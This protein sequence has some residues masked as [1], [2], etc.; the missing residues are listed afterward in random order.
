MKLENQV[1]SLNL[2]KKL[3]ELGAKQESLFYW[4]D[5]MKYNGDYDLV[6]LHAPMVKE[7]G[8]PI[9]TVSAFTATEL[10]EALSLLGYVALPLYNPELDKWVHYGLGSEPSV[11]G[12][13]TMI[14]A[15]HEVDSRAEMLIYLLENNL[16]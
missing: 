3:K 2:A 11:L 10:G 7:G 16:I 8:G 15:S 5:G 9:D 14:S 1:V 13:G 6:Y 4:T 12:F